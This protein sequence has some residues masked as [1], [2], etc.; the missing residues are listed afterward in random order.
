MGRQRKDNSTYDL[1]PPCACGCGE[2]VRKYR[3]TYVG[4]H[5]QQHMLRLYPQP[6]C[7]CGCGTPTE[8]R[9]NQPWKWN[10]YIHNHNH[11]GVLHHKWNGGQ[12]L[13]ARGYVMQWCPGHP[14]ARKSGHV[15][16][17]TLVA[18]QML[19]RFLKPGEEVHHINENTQ[20][21]RPANLQVMTHAAHAAWHG[22]LRAIVARELVKHR[23]ASKRTHPDDSV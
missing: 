16:R 5:R 21:D 14:R 20:D 11:R 15:K 17:A 10:K 4:Q 3:G 18:E 6:L 7:A 8:H 1:R 2:R 13:T 12:F 23:R 22:T 19:G 9:T